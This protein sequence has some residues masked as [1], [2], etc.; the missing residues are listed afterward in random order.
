MPM[1]SGPPG[2]GWWRASDGRW[3]PPQPT[4]QPAPG[5]RPPQPAQPLAGAA[6]S[7]GAPPVKKSH[8]G[9]W[10][11]VI[12]IVA[13]VFVAGGL[14]AYWVYREVSSTVSGAL[15]GGALDCPSSNE[16]GDLVGSPV[17]G[18]TGGN[19]VIAGGC[20]YTGD[21]EV[22]IVSGSKLVADE[23]LASMVGEGNAANADVQSIDV[24][25]K[26]Q[27]WASDSKSSAIAVGDNA[28]FSV[29]VQ[30]KDFGT[31]PD[32]TDA[33]IAILKKVLH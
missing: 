19:M 15:G 33:A 31:I 29:E 1:T 21:I 4:Q 26:G 13:V 11:T 25:D 22:V 10:I 7:Q 8:R 6:F 30:G 3:Y 24:G 16:I 5:Y 28:I 20:Y 9:I 17:T 23:Q 18:P 14:G 27:A 12:V 2:P 32:K